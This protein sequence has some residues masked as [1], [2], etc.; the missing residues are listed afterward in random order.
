MLRGFYTAASGMLAQQ[1]QTEML[2]NNLANA[3]TTGFKADQSSIRSFPEMLL[4]R[5]ESK[6]VA[7]DNSLQL[8]I[9]KNVG[10][11]STGVYVQEVTPLFSQG[12]IQETELKTDIA[13]IN[14]SMPAD[15]NGKM[16][17]V[18][19]VVENSSGEMR[20]TRNGNFTLDGTGFLTTSEGNYVLDQNNE[21]IQLNS[22]DF[23][24]DQDGSISENNQAVARLGVAFA[25][26][27]DSLVKEGGGLFRAAEDE[28]TDAYTEAEVSFTLNQGVIEGSNV[29]ESQTMTDL[30]AAYRSFEANQK[31]LQAYDRSMDKAVNEVGKLG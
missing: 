20:Y 18:M 15:A 19:F 22:D 25:E 30:M 14:G 5:M 17:T 9:N 16:G 7:T 24:I 10:S 11:I 29:D 1:R 8:P 28:L 2:T 12:D 13:L 4:Q 31:M 23:T 21:R 26:N 3:N 27:P 6:T